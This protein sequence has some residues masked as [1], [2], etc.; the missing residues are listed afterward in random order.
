[1]RKR[2]KGKRTIVFPTPKIKTEELKEDI[3]QVTQFIRS[4]AHITAS[5][6]DT[7][8]EGQRTVINHFVETNLTA[9]TPEKLHHQKTI[10]LTL[11]LIAGIIAIACIATLIIAIG[12]LV[13]KIQT[14]SKQ[15]KQR[16]QAYELIPTYHNARTLKTFQQEAYYSSG[17]SLEPPPLPSPVIEN[18]RNSLYN[19]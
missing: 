4:V 19:K 16:R 6:L 12:L 5:T 2:E 11:V 7:L 10:L 1:M 18:H 17:E 14:N 15:T 3:N 8:F 9:T 13:E